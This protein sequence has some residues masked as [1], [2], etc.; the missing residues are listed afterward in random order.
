MFLFFDDDMSGKQK[1]IHL[2]LVAVIFILALDYPLPV[3]SN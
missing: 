1:C 3:G 2:R